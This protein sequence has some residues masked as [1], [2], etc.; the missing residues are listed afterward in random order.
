MTWNVGASTGI[1]TFDQ[2]I[3]AA[4]S[5]TARWTWNLGGNTGSPSL[6]ISGGTNQIQFNGIGAGA[7]PPPDWI[8]YDGLATDLFGSQLLPVPAITQYPAVP[9]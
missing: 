5:A 9:V 3:P 2:V 1:M 7:G 4:L 8:S 6:V